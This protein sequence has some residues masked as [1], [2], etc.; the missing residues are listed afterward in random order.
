MATK[1]HVIL[2]RF[3]V[4]TWMHDTIELV[5]HLTLWNLSSFSLSPPL[6]WSTPLSLPWRCGICMHQHSTSGIIKKKKNKKVTHYMLTH[7][8]MR[9]CGLTCLVVCISDKIRDIRER[10]VTIRSE[11]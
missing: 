1:V 9:G 8:G 3:V 6:V 2:H 4:L 7:G 11:I 5:Q 10:N